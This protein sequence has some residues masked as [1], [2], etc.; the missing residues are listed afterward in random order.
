[1]PFLLIAAL[2][3]TMTYIAPH[4]HAFCE[5]TY[6]TEGEGTVLIGE[7]EYRAHAGSIFVIPPNVNLQ[8]DYPFPSAADL[9][10]H[11]ILYL[12][13][14]G[15]RTVANLMQMM[16]HRYIG[17]KKNDTTLTLMHELLV[18]LLAEKC[19]TLQADPAVEE[20]RRLLTLN[21][22][23]PQLSLAAVLAS[24]GYHKDHIRRRFIAACGMTPCEYLTALRIENAKTLL[25]R[26][27]EMG[28]S[29]AEIGAMCGYYDGHYFSKVFKKQVGVSPE[30]FA[31]RG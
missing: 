29:V 28:L 7:K 16:L 8:T 9:F 13:D 2:P 22:N 1:M 15:E 20:V 31:E 19:A 27:R 11:G 30:R 23:D 25:G 21:Y 18:R 6:C 12:E 17:G 3:K 14:D 24:T 5:I 10:G 4:R 26:R